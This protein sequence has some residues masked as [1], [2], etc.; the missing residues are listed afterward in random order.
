MSPDQNNK[1]AECIKKRSKS[2]VR[3]T[4]KGELSNIENKKRKYML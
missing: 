1:T 4:V 3:A 2:R